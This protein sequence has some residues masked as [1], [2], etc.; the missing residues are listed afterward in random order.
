MPDLDDEEESLPRFE[1][2][3]RSRR[4]VTPSPKVAVKPLLLGTKKARKWNEVVVGSAS[5][6]MY[7]F[8]MEDHF[9]IDAI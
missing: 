4:S 1:N 6:N 5:N 2:S 7:V 8:A 9:M 3:K